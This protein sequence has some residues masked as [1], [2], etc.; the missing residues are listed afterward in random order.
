MSGTAVLRTKLQLRSASKNAQRL[1]EL[2]EMLGTL[3]A[4]ARDIVRLSM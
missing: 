1:S 2:H 4:T 3:E